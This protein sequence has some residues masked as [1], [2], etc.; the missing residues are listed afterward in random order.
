MKEEEGCVTEGWRKIYSVTRVRKGRTDKWNDRVIGMGFGLRKRIKRFK[1]CQHNFVIFDRYLS[2]E[3][4]LFT[5]K[6]ILYH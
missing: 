3:K 6:Y 1:I 5:K 2:H 4:Y